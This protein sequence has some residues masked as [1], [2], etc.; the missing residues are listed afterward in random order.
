MRRGPEGKRLHQG[1][2]APSVMYPDEGLRQ[3][4][5]E[6]VQK[7]VSWYQNTIHDEMGFRDVLVPVQCGDPDH[8]WKPHPWGEPWRLDCIYVHTFLRTDF[9][10]YGMMELVDIVYE[11][12]LRWHLSELANSG[13]L[14]KVVYDT[15]SHAR[16]DLMRACCDV[17]EDQ[18]ETLDE[19]VRAAK[20]YESANQARS[21][22]DE[23]L[24]ARTDG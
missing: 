9:R 22:L 20:A 16:I 12:A 11:S 1:Q 2:A 4:A 21:L 14:T 5:M 19:V 3:R 6:A 17:L 18:Q 10:R 24:K 13:V 8:L 7:G 23:A 15:L